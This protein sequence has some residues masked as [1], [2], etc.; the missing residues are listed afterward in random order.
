MNY[1][2]TV[3]VLLK[4][5]ITEIPSTEKFSKRKVNERK[6]KKA[7]FFSKNNRLDKKI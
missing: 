2:F 1:P 5:K 7:I 3:A 6:P 4:S